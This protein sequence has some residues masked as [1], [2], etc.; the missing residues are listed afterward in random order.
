M[1]L[2]DPIFSAVCY[3]SHSI[4]SNNPID[5]AKSG[6][7]RRPVVTDESLVVAAEVKM[8][9]YITISSR[10]STAAQEKWRHFA[11]TSAVIILYISVLCWR[12]AAAATTAADDDELS[13]HPPTPF[14]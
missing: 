8:V 6:G 11:C 7:E 9:G 4:G 1:K 14:Q 2:A 10:Y 3:I 5:L 13:T 12:A